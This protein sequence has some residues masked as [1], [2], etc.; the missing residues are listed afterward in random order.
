VRIHHERSS[1][2]EPDVRSVVSEMT[3]QL[4]KPNLVRKN[5]NMFGAKLWL[6]VFNFNSGEQWITVFRGMA[7]GQSPVQAG[8]YGEEWGGCTWPGNVSCQKNALIGE[9]YSM[10]LL[11]VLGS[12]NKI[13]KYIYIYNIYIYL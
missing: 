7:E 11:L 13:I 4:H 3:K 9:T 5:V 2:A 10:W 1:V 12:F 6:F 8:D